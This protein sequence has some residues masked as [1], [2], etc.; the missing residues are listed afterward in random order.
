MTP[1]TVMAL[2]QEA[3]LLAVKVAAPPLLA[4][5]LAGLLV[6]VVQTA[7]SVQDSTL[8]FVPKAVAT[9]VALYVTFAWMLEEVVEFVHRVMA[10]V[11]S[12]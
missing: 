5:L 1:D 6:G 10:L 7:T 2:A 3:L 11:G 12:L 8:S 4:G 9:L